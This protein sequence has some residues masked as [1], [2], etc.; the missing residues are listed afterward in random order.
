MLGVLARPTLTAWHDG[1]A[2]AFLFF[3]SALRRTYVWNSAGARRRRKSS[4]V[5]WWLQPYSGQRMDDSWYSATFWLMYCAMQ[6][7]QW[8]WLSRQH[9]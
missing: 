2:R 4:S 8:A 5:R 9:Q 6:L 7:L 3:C 1:H